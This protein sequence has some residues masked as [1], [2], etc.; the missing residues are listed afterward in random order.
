MPGTARWVG[1]IHGRAVGDAAPEVLCACS[2]TAARRP[3][4]EVRRGL[5]SCRARASR[6]AL[7]A[8]GSGRGGRPCRPTALRCS[9]LGRAAE[10]TALPAGAPFRQPR[11]VGSR[12][13]LARADPGTALLVAPDIA[14]SGQRLP[15]PPPPVACGSNTTAAQQRRARVGG[16]APPRRREV[17]GSWPRAQRASWPDSSRLSERSDRR[18]RSEF[19]D[20]AT[21]PRIA[22]ESAL[23]AGRRGE[24]PPPARARLCRTDT[25]AAKSSGRA[26]SAASEQGSVRELL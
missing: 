14:P 7:P 3:L 4:V 19:C 25:G 8:G 13:A 2:S 20:G 12:S 10:L 22:G 24:A 16:G 18:E 21:R 5:L 6:Q 23:R 11:Q 9:R 26:S 17:Q 15:R 1:V